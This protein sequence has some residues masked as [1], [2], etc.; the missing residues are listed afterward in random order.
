M[1]FQFY[2]YS[3]RL[4]ATAVPLP[5]YRCAASVK[6]GIKN[7]GPLRSFH[8]V[9]FREPGPS[10]K[11]IFRTFLYRSCQR[12]AFSFKLASIFL[13]KLPPPCKFVFSSMTKH[14]VAA[15]RQRHSRREKRPS[16]YLGGRFSVFARCAELLERVAL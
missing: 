6:R 7:N 13:K 10:G 5:R 12:S 8:K 1:N 4:R 16:G 3:C 2:V 14:Y 11:G 9:S 15:F